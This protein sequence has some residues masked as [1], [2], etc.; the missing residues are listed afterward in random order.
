M[1]EY[2]R[3]NSELGLEFDR[4]V[5]DHPAFA[6]RI[7]RGRKSSYRFRAIVASTR[8]RG[9]WRSTPTRRDVRSSS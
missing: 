4:Y 3:L 7:P 2:V 6:A 9:V 8:G 5:L 1:E